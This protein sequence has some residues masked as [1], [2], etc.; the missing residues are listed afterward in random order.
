MPS[1]KMKRIKDRVKN[2]A[3]GILTAT[4]MGVALTTST[5]CAPRQQRPV[6]IAEEKRE[7]PAAY[8]KALLEG[9]TAPF[10]E[11]V[12][13]VK[14]LAEEAKTL[15]SQE[16]SPE[17]K[18]GP[19]KLPRVLIE[20]LYKS[21]DLFLRGLGV[22]GYAVLG[23]KGK[24]YR[25]LLEAQ[26]MGN[27]E[28]EKLF[29]LSAIEAARIVNDRRAARH[30]A[31]LLLKEEDEGIRSAA[32]VALL[33][34][35]YGYAAVKDLIA[36]DPSRIGAFKDLYVLFYLNAHKDDKERIAKEVLSLGREMVGRA[37]L[38]NYTGWWEL[39]SL[40]GIA[41]D[42]P[43]TT[44][45]VLKD[46][47]RRNPFRDSQRREFSE[48]IGQAYI[49]IINRTVTSTLSQLAVKDISSAEMGEGIMDLPVLIAK[50]AVL[51]QEKKDGKAFALLK[52]HLK[53][54][55]AMMEVDES[56]RPRYLSRYR[57]DGQAAF[58]LAMAAHAFY[59]ADRLSYDVAERQVIVDKARSLLATLVKY[60]EHYPRSWEAAMLYGAM[61]GSPIYDY[62]ISK[63]E[64]PERGVVAAKAIAN[65][66]IYAGTV[67]AGSLTNYILGTKAEGE[68]LDWLG[69]ALG[70][71]IYNDALKKASLPM[72]EP[73]GTKIPAPIQLEEELKASYLSAFQKLLERGAVEGAIH[74]L[75]GLTMVDPEA[76]L[77]QEFA[78]AMGA[79]GEKK[80]LTNETARYA[81]LLALKFRQPEVAVGALE[82]LVKAK[83]WNRVSAA[84][85]DIMAYFGSRE[86]RNGMVVYRLKGPIGD[87]GPFLEFLKGTANDPTVPPHVRG[88]AKNLINFLLGEEVYVF[89]MHRMPSPYKMAVLYPWLGEGARG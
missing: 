23:D 78:S 48:L 6:V 70:R 31:E 58:F 2:S 5:S 66:A 54:F 15:S 37:S 49:D 32:T 26:S 7:E 81:V 83:D 84:L 41:Y 80:L 43:A 3:K 39:L 79:L 85:T 17:R 13:M 62:A 18:I 73:F 61:I 51:K 42:F 71:A 45:S 34:M 46:L 86:V 4:L 65:L 35:E 55:L 69:I 82:G 50:A 30:V 60:I 9:A 27:K 44:F 22:V 57:E 56:G 36:E 74:I 67:S 33:N 76:D 68:V 16:V 1:L 87:L 24:V 29:K 10:A 72:P 19:Y 47:L 11:A 64:D 59:L 40:S 12:K 28:G 63:V 77:S 52:P 20:E 75:W 38:E 89:R 53:K 21:R 25:A 14:A 88:T 8:V